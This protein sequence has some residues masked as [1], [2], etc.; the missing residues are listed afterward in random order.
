MSAKYA[1]SN[2]PLASSQNFGLHEVGRHIGSHDAS[3]GK[4][5]GGEEG[6]PA[7]RPYRSARHDA[8]VEEYEHGEGRED[9]LCA[10]GEREV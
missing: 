7:G 10:A 4:S 1:T 8:Q 5:V 9:G 6:A 2:K 3:T